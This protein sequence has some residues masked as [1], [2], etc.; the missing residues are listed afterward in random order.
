VQTH[1]GFGSNVGD[2]SV[3]LAEGLARLAASG[4]EPVAVSGVWETDPLDCPAS[5]KFLNLVAEL[6]TERDPRELLELMLRVESELGRVRRG[7]NAPR[8]LDLDLLLMGDLERNEPGLVLPHPRMWERRFV[9]APL[10]EIA[11]GLRN[12][13]TGRTVVEEE[14]ALRERQ[15]GVVR[16]GTL[17]WPRRPPL[18]SPPST[19]D[20]LRP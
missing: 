19:G 17:A 11:P 5:D 3:H 16:I 6:E 2:R 20:I 10:A 1:I 18:Y 15:P 12:P 8:T 9:L 13:R 4:L 7:R 14:R